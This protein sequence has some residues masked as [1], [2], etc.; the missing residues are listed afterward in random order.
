VKVRQAANYALNKS[1]FIRYDLL[2]NGEPVSTLATPGQIGYNTD[3]QPYPF[4]L[5]KALELDPRKWD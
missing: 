1:E 4:D 2:G 5:K 3:L